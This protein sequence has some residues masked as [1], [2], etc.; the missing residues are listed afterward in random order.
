LT[1]RA[2]RLDDGDIAVSLERTTAA[3]RLDLFVRASGLTAREAE[4]VAL[5]STGADT[6]ELARRMFVSEHTVQDHLKSVF[7]KTGVTNR[8]ALVA[9]AVGR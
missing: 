8:R 2:A 1:L 9:R 7:A 4:L 3:D 6:K 5:L